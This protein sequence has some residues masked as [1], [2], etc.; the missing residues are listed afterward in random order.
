[1]CSALS[2]EL[3]SGLR[4]SLSSTLEVAFPSV[5]SLSFLFS[6]LVASLLLGVIL[7]LLV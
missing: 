2:A 7:F 1:M 5:T 4:G 6:R 3:F